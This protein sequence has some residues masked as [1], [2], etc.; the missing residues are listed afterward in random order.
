M[1]SQTAVSIVTGGLP[2][3]LGSDARRKIAYLSLRMHVW[4]N[5]MNWF[6]VIVDVTAVGCY[7]V[8]YSHIGHLCWSIRSLARVH[9][10]AS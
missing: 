1:D 4:L 6:I 8:L 3:W 5:L 7:A 9:T 2:V 10:V